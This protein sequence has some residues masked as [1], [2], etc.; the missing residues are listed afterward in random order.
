MNQIE[1]LREKERYTFADLRTVVELLRSPEGCPWD[2]EQTHES[3]RKDFIEE[4]YEVAETIDRADLAG[5]REELGDVLFQV[6]FHARIAEEDG[7][8]DLED[9]CD[10]ICRKMVI[11]HPHVFGEQVTA[12]DGTAL[13][14]WE[15][16]KDR[17]HERKSAEEALRAIP[18]TLPALM[19][20]DKLGSKSRKLGFDCADVS[21]AMQ[22]VE[23]ELSEV[24]AAIPEGDPSAVE[25]EFGDLLLAVVNASRLAGVNAEQALERACEKYLDRFSLVQKQCDEAGKAIVDTSREELRLYWQNAKTFLR[26]NGKNRCKKT[27]KD[28]QN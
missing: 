9:V 17:T 13:R 28:G 1:L 22:K 26:T 12:P 2:R 3:I 7:W 5:M 15:A 6:V 24:R 21:E 16:I 20:A 10:E 27:E 25:E 14:D 8:F 11:R 23:E 18:R 19:R 4:V